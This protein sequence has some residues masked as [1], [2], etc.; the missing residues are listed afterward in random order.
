[1][2]P[3]N[4]MSGTNVQSPLMTPRVCASFR[5]D[6]A[7]SRG[8]SVAHT[9]GAAV[10][11]CVRAASSWLQSLPSQLVFLPPQ[12]LFIPPLQSPLSCQRSG[13]EL[14]SSLDDP[15]Y[16]NSG[17]IFASMVASTTALLPTTPTFTTGGTISGV[18]WRITTSAS[19]TDAFCA[20]GY[21]QS[22][23]FTKQ[24]LQ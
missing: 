18:L 1:M 19:R 16:Q 24:R 12:S 11:R 2:E 4:A 22:R 9:R 23:P 14:Q 5:Y 15:E 6:G 7:H 20:L 21:L 10:V 8:R 17:S 13:L 3:E